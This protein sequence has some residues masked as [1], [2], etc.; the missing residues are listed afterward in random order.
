MV[1]FDLYIQG[2]RAMKLQQY[3][4][5]S[6][7]ALLFACG[8]GGGGGGSSGE[9]G[10]AAVPASAP[11]SLSGTIFFSFNGTTK[12]VNLA[13][14]D[15]TA[16]TLER[17]LNGQPV[18]NSPISGFFFDLSPD[19][20]TLYFLDDY[21]ISTA[22]ALKAV[23][24]ATGASKIL[25]TTTASNW[26]DVSVSP[27][28]SKFAIVYSRGTI[29][30]RGIYIVSRSGATLV[31]Y[32]AK[33]G[34]SSSVYWTADNRLLY[35]HS[36]GIYLTNVGDLL[37]SSVV[38][39]ISNV[40]SM[41]ISPDGKKIAYSVGGHI[42]TMNIDGTNKQQV[43]VSDNA[44][45]RPRWSP[46]G[47]YLVFKSSIFAAA[48]NNGGTIYQLAVIPADGKQYVLKKE[49][50]GDVNSTSNTITGSN[51]LVLLKEKTKDGTFKNLIADEFFWR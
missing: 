23:D 36:D 10:P 21:F 43:T 29:P 32:A 40:D 20:K 4:V 47:K 27:D 22:D 42:W 37:N 48:G 31:Y 45:F 35:T 51:G 24:L 6:C 7:A 28:Q 8:G 11:S 18:P 19:N 46:D 39:A 34:D 17:T 16:L 44:E 30:R 38:A 50:L 3:L 12:K 49:V 41:S 13:N 33:A 26:S 14:G 15:T 25:F 9:A 1:E 5:L 2:G